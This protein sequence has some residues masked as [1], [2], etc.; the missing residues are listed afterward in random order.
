[1]KRKRE[2]V[3]AAESARDKQNAGV[4]RQLSAPLRCDPISASR[5]ALHHCSPPH[6]GQCAFVLRI[7]EGAGGER[8]HS[9]QHAGLRFADR[10][11][12][13]N[14]ALDGGLLRPIKRVHRMRIGRKAASAIKYSTEHCVEE[15]GRAQ[16]PWRQRGA[17]IEHDHDSAGNQL[18]ATGAYSRVPIFHRF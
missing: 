5:S 16:T 3:A 11:M 8:E 17:G 15:K 10:R 2:R 18:K 13:T 1:M 4:E 6:D 14:P 9:A 12:L 7:A